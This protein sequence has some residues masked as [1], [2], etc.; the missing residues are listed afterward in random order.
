LA[1]ILSG[2][3]WLCVALARPLIWSQWRL[4]LLLVIVLSVPLFVLRLAPL[5]L[6]LSRNL[7]PAALSAMLLI[8]LLGR[9]LAVL[10]VIVLALAGGFIQGNDFQTTAMAL[11]SG[12]VAI[13]SLRSFK[14]RRD[15]MRAGLYL[16]GV[17]VLLL[18]GFHLANYSAESAFWAEL[19]VAVA[20]AALSPI[21]VLG[22]IP[23]FEGIFGLTT[24]LRLLELVDLNQPLLRELA[25]KSPG[26][27]HHSL[28]V[29]SLA[30]AAA[31]EIG[32]NPL[33][34]RAGAY[35]HDIGKMEIKE[36]FIEN[37]ETGSENIHDHLPPSK[38][39]EIVLSHVQRGLELAARYNLPSQVAAFIT[40][41]HGK[42]R[43]AYFYAKAQRES[44]RKVDESR[45]RYGGPKPRSK[46][47]AIIMLADATEAATRTLDHP[48]TKELG[49]MVDK[50]V[51][52][53][54]A[55]GNL[56]ESPLSLS[57]LR[58]IKEAFLRVLSGIHHQR[59]QYP[60]SDMG[61]DD[62][63]MSV[64]TGKNAE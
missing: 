51:A 59:I 9:S 48:S 28:M 46:E 49:E 27:Y 54:L 60:G 52:G 64:E 53:R 50:L 29:G 4:M 43:L 22:L 39:A 2:F 36:Y 6:G 45:F 56:D 20:N 62:N 7:F 32:A 61:T 10:G 58:S 23:L 11:A 24:D 1:V 19:G 18:V 26:T 3:L 37:Q 12:G 16:A 42:T 15:I 40:E 8:I 31:I 33:L 47:T 57:E 17:A 21:L 13:I 55:E 34:T 44:G 5:E 63:P 41:H 14:G 35:Y 30:E 38:S 25:M